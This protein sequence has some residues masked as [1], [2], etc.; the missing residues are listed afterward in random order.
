M[1]EREAPREGAG[2]GH[3]T[4]E[5]AHATPRDGVVLAHY[6]AKYSTPLSEPKYTAAAL[7][8]TTV[9]ASATATNPAAKYRFMIGPIVA[10]PCGW[11]TRRW[12]AAGNAN[13]QQ[14]ACG[15]RPADPHSGVSLSRQHPLARYDG[16]RRGIAASPG[17]REGQCA[18]ETIG[19]PRSEAWT[20]R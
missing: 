12:G 16:L 3:V 5:Q 9:K 1:G 15:Q 13:I 10:L 11:I 17:N 18:T 14:A 8:P 7:P 2:G 19:P 20:S 4:L 6:P